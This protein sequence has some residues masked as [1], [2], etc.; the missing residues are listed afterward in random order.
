VQERAERTD[1]ERHALVHRRLAQVAEPQVDDG[2]GEGAR[3]AQTSSIAREESTPMTRIPSEAIGT[4]IL[5][6][7][8]PSSTTGPPERRA[9]SR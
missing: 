9:S 6:V 4:A 3:S 7:P 2:A 5:P 1:D 8:T